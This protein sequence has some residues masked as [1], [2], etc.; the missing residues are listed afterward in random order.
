MMQGIEIL[1]QE[2]IMG[3]GK[4]FV[5]F[6]IGLIAALIIGVIIEVFMD[7]GLGFVAGVLIMVLSG[8]IAMVVDGITAQPT[9]K[10]KYKVT[11]SD[12]V[13]MNKFLEKYEIID[14]EGKIM[15]IKERDDAND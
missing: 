13:S 7:H 14:Q 12:D 8:G 1:A 5:V 4:G 11:I 10:Y 3:S 6:L 2:P 15:T 9:G